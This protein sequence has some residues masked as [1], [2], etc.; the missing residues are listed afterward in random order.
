MSF[1]RSSLRRGRLWLVLARNCQSG[2]GLGARV[3]VTEVAPLKALE[4][5]MDGFDVMPMVKAAAIGDI[6][7]TATGDKS[8]IDGRHYPHLKDGA[9]ICN[10]GHFTSRSTSRRSKSSRLKSGAFANSSINIF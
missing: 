3:V 2:E 9:I 10:S 1:C 8:V 5:V 7:V 4:A 6:F